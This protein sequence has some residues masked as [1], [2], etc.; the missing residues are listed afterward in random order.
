MH[1]LCPGINFINSLTQLEKNITDLI[2][3]YQRSNVRFIFYDFQLEIEENIDFFTK[4]WS[5]LHIITT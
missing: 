1:K 3:A 2:S 5:L 4:L